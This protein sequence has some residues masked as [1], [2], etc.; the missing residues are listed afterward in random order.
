VRETELEG[1]AAQEYA[2]RDAGL[3]GAKLG[4]KFKEQLGEMATVGAPGADDGEVAPLDAGAGDAG[5][6]GDAATVDSTVADA[7]VTDSTV[8]DDDTVTDDTTVTDAPESPSTDATLQPAPEGK[9]D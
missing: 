3:G 9:H 1:E 5:D 7:T 6:V 8:T 4:D 2:A